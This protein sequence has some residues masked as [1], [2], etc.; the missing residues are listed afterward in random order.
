MAINYKKL[1]AA[2]TRDE[3]RWVELQF[4]RGRL[5]DQSA[6]A[7]ADVAEATMGELE[8]AVLYAKGCVAAA[9]PNTIAALVDEQVAANLEKAVADMSTGLHKDEDELRNLGR[10]T[11]LE[12]QR[13]EDLRRKQR[14]KEEAEHEQ[15]CREQGRKAMVAQRELSEQK[16]E[17][18]RDR[19]DK[20]ELQAAAATRRAMEDEYRMLYEGVQY[21]D[22]MQEEKDRAAGRTARAVATVRTAAEHAELAKGRAL[23]ERAETRAIDSAKLRAAALQEELDAD[24]ALLFGQIDWEKAMD[25]RMAD[26][27]RH[28]AE[29]ADRFAELDARRAADR[30]ALA[31]DRARLNDVQGHLLDVKKAFAALHPEL[32]RL[33]RRHRVDLDGCAAWQQLVDVVKHLP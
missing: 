19:S 26:L 17:A 23:Q 27:H 9:R 7:L 1:R 14:A 18:D 33:C 30:A 6:Q 8:Q 15:F 3:Q 13:A 32:T 22:L 31:A 29:L 28:E 12:H 4:A 25:E 2:Q 5:Y 20:A 16:R 24:R 11:H 21:A 10:V